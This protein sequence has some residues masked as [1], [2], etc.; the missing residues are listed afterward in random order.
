M[1]NSVQSLHPPGVGATGV[2]DGLGLRGPHGPSD[3]K[4]GGI[5]YRAVEPGTL[6]IR[7]KHGAFVVPH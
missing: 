1:K 4:D 5:I 3:G 2:N 7:A 6:I